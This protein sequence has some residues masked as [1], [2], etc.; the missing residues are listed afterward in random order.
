MFKW[1]A[2]TPDDSED[3]ADG[4]CRCFYVGVAGDLEIT[5]GD[6]NIVNFANCPVGIMPAMGI[7]L[8][9]N[10]TAGSILAGY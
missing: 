1:V 7:R 5:D 6:G 4:L 9:E 2:V 8:N 3:F 10:T